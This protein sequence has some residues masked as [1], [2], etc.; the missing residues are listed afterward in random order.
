MDDHA[1]K[2]RVK[3]ALIGTYNAGKTTLVTRW[4]TGTFIPAVTATIG[5]SFSS[6][7][8][9]SN[10]IIEFWDTS[11]M[12]RFAS[13]TRQYCRDASLII[14]VYDV[15]T[16]TTVGWDRAVRSYLK[17]VDN[18]RLCPGIVWLIGAKTDI[19]ATI[20]EVP[21]DIRE[22]IAGHSLVSAKTGTEITSSWDAMWSALLRSKEVRDSFPLSIPPATFPLSG[23]ARHSSS[24]RWSCCTIS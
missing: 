9:D 7:S 13:S 8:D 18:T 11:G 5:T 16:I 12:E 19:A 15:S 23:Y 4:K 22:K 14:I 21:V 6:R 20:P 3:C 17:M 2:K 24:K 1:Y 10:Y